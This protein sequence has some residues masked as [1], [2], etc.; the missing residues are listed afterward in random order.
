M[1]RYWRLY[2]VFWRNGFRREIEFRANFWAKVITN[3]AWLFFFI[4]LVQVIYAHTNA[5]A[6][7]NRNDAF[8]LVATCYWMSS[9]ASITF[10]RNL[11]MLPSLVRLGTFDFVLVKPVSSLFWTSFRF[12]NMDEIGTLIGSLAMLGYAVSRMRP[13]PDLM[14]VMEYFVLCFSGLTMYYSLYLLTMTFSFWLVRV[15]NLS[16][17]IDTVLYMARFPTDIFRGVLQRILTFIIPLAFIATIP[18]KAMLGRMEWWLLPVG[19]GLAAFLLTG[20]VAFWRFA[21]KYYTS[22][23]S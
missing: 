18:S 14:Q 3:F 10:F 13:L 5:I 23:S 22:A 6:G 1:R 19:V 7:W 4:A 15:D 20:A 17:L 8:L 9:I 21:T 11:G 12:V 2:R 16:A